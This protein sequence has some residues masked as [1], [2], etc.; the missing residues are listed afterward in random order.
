[1]PADKFLS[2]QCTV[3]KFNSLPAAHLCLVKAGK[4][5]DWQQAL[6]DELPTDD[7]RASARLTLNSPLDFFFCLLLLSFPSSILEL[8]LGSHCLFS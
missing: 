7:T 8:L 5:G 4:R 1:M 6:A 2:C 3:M